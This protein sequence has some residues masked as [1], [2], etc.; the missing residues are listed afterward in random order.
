MYATFNHPR[1]N[2]L[3]PENLGN[4]FSMLSDAHIRVLRNTRCSLAVSK[5]RT[6][7][8]QKSLEFRGAN[9]W[10]KLDSEVKLA[11]SIQSFKSKL[12]ALS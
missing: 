3:A 6:A 9:A 5:R 11:P 4:I 2:D 12:E 10:N 1:M 8:G 7:Y